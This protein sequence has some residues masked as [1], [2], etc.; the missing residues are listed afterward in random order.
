MKGGEKVEEKREARRIHHPSTQNGIDSA[1]HL[2]KKEHGIDEKCLWIKPF[3]NNGITQL[4][5][6]PSALNKYSASDFH[7]SCSSTQQT[8]PRANGNQEEEEEGTHPCLWE[9]T[10]I[11]IVGGN[12]ARGP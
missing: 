8:H 3:Y 5:A 10:T 4:F 12:A 6:Q 1:V 9:E 11:D 2:G 7:Y